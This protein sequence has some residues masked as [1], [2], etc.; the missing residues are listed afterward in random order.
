MA[1]II[2]SDSSVTQRPVNAVTGTRTSGPTYSDA[3]VRRVQAIYSTWKDANPDEDSPPAS[4]RKSI[5]RELRKH[6]RVMEVER[7]AARS[8][9]AMLLRDFWAAASA[10][11]IAE[12]DRRHQ[13]AVQANDAA[14]QQDLGPIELPQHLVEQRN[15]LKNTIETI[16]GLTDYERTH[17]LMLLQFDHDLG[18]RVFPIDLKLRRDVLRHQIDQ[19]KQRMGIGLSQLRGTAATL[20][21]RVA[22]QSAGTEADGRDAGEGLAADAE[23]D[24]EVVPA[25]SAPDS[26]DASD[27]TVPGDDREFDQERALDW[28][29]RLPE[30][31]AREQFPSTLLTKLH[32]SLEGAPPEVEDRALCIGIKIIQHRLLN[33]D[34]ADDPRDLMQLDEPRYEHWEAT[35]RIQLAEAES[36]SPADDSA[37]GAAMMTQTTRA[38]AQSTIADKGSR[39]VSEP[40]QPGALMVDDGAAVAVGA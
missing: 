3:T 13:N 6:R 36:D 7:A 29:A 37:L 12:R 34:F 27:L 40:V 8:T 25:E 38:A 11:K 18:V 17:A 16:R 26:V 28:L 31:A 1:D 32:K 4:V 10:S 22:G 33:V 20:A 30:L 35:T 14:A 24:A 2:D 15:D 5:S 39:L 23:P 21:S 9:I 19:L